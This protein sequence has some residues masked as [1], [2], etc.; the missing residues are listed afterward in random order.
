M[1]SAWLHCIGTATPPHD[2]HAAFLAYA[3]SGVTGD[4]ER[5]LFD[6]M[7]E[8]SGIEHRYAVL[9]PG[10][11][12]D[13]EID[14]AGFYKRGQ[15]PGTAERMVVYEREALKLAV[16]A[17]HALAS[18]DGLATQLGRVTH[19][20]VA[21]CTGFVAPGLDVLLIDALGLRDDVQRTLVGFMGCSAALPA[22]RVAQQTV[23]A[24]PEALVLVVN[25]ELSSLHLRES[26][27][28]EELLSF[29]LFG[30]GASAALVGAEPQGAE[31]LDF[32]SKLLPDSRGLIT[33][34]VGNQGFEMHLSGLVPGRIAEALSAE[35]QR[36]DAG[37]LLRGQRVD[38]YS[39]WAVHAGGRSVLDA[40]ERGLALPPAALHDSRA[41]L[42]AVGNV[43]SATVMFVLRRM[44]EGARPGAQGMA[45][46]FGPG[47][48]AESMRFRIA[49]LA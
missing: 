48:S 26:G 8:R 31:L 20:V 34:D 13:G 42:R 37:G 18:A 46:A 10:R 27:A 39:L 29:M 9:R 24:D 36:R 45:L 3:R 28:V 16:Q 17:V 5:Q 4:R 6:R 47:L 19:L 33:W 44:L 30:D 15:F 38:D 49:A 32:R 2:V 7:A 35:S 25:V 22:L 14:D 23:C 41:V 43:S 40:V 1:T 11:L 21:S 12:A